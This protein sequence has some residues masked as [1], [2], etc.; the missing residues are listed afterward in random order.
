M[1]AVIRKLIITM[2]KS[3]GVYHG[4]LYNRLIRLYFAITAQK[5]VPYWATSDLTPY[6]H[7]LRMQALIAD[8]K[9]EKGME[10]H[11]R[12]LSALLETNRMEEFEKRVRKIL[13]DRQ[14]RSYMAH[15]PYIAYEIRKMGVNDADVVKSADCYERI[16]GR[17][18]GFA[19]K[20]FVEGKTIAV[21]GNGPGELGKGLGSEIDQH[22]IVIR[23][24]NHNLDGF[25]NDYGRRTDVW[26]KAIIDFMNHNV[27]SK[28]GVKFVFYA[29]DLNRH[30]V[31]DDF[32]S[33]MDRE[34]Q[35]YDFD[36]S[37]RFDRS[38]IV[39]AIGGHCTTG[40]LMIE[41]LRHSKMRYLDVYGFSFL[42]GG[43]SVWTHFNNDVSPEK[44][45]KEIVGHPKM[46]D[47]WK[48]LKML[49]PTGRRLYPVEE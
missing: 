12:L 45:A 6:L 18:V 46:N 36:F 30:F 17:H 49:I 31:P 29:W 20:R 3:F 33:A 48:Y 15:Y 27:D 35:V 9:T 47:E 28:E 2:A 39:D 14:C 38:P 5:Y 37:D 4:N 1:L 34:L 32:L 25:E 23:I 21:V 24:N 43:C 11:V 8:R 19:L 26:A 13:L 16:V 7:S 10:C 41:I 40:A 22:D 42:A 44:L